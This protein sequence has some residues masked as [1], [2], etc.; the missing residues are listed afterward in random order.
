M[1]KTLVT[2]LLVILVAH[3]LAALG[4]LGYGWATGRFTAERMAQ[5]RATWRGEKLVP[6]VEEKVVQQREESPRAAGVRIAAAEN[7]REMMTRELELLRQQLVN[8]TDTVNAAQKRIQKERA[9]LERAQQEFAA[10]LAQER[11][12]AQDEGFR[13]ALEDYSRMN[14]KYVKDDFMHLPDEDA[15][16]FLGAM[17]PDVATAILERF[18]T[19]EEQQKRLRLMNLLRMQVRN[20]PQPS[21]PVALNQ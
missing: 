7:E 20:T 8:M 16:R 9:Q 5:Y 4:L 12:R 1:A 19:P 14:P 6:P 11:A 13:K 2:T 17:K 21:E 10:K 18:K 15:V 3:A